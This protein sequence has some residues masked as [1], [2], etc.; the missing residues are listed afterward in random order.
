MKTPRLND[1]A[2]APYNPRDIDAEALAA[3]TCSLGE[4]GDLSGI[5]WNQRTGNLVTGHQRLRSLKERHGD[6]L[7][8][9]RGV[10]HAGAETFRVRVVDWPLA[11]EKA[12][13]I[14]A[15]VYVH[16]DET[17]LRAG[18]TRLGDDLVSSWYQ[19]DGAEEKTG[20]ERGLRV[21]TDFPGAR[22][23]GRSAQ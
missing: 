10:I 20:P 18:M 12:A 1:L 16:P 17:M 5:T 19:D 22:G 3:L 6:V 4:F 11:K 8:M 15:E 7:K 21:P 9:R 23:W 13:N 2:P 14:A